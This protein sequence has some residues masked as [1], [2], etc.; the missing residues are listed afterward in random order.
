[1]LGVGVTAI[2]RPGALANA[3]TALSAGSASKP[4][5]SPLEP[6]TGLVAAR[7]EEAVVSAGERAEA[8]APALPASDAPVVAAAAG[9]A[10]AAEE[11]DT[12][13]EEEAAL[14]PPPAAADDAPAQT[15]AKLA[16]GDAKSAEVTLE[17]RIQS[18]RELM[19]A[20]KELR[21]FHQL[22]YLGRSNYGDAQA[23]RAW[24]EAAAQVKA[25]GEA[26]RTARRWAAI[27][28]STDALIHLAR[29]E[30]AVGRRGRAV[31]LLKK[32]VRSN[33]E[34]NDA[35]QLLAS[36]GWDPERLAKR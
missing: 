17:T 10:D 24:S 6:T 5:V 15:E 22:R 31:S 28:P 9:D 21:G 8:P 29:M 34:A 20:G 23:L 25:W 11:G 13:G 4:Q 33:P 30:R 3:R 19:A 14:E 36:F 18:A 32:I 2:G 12:D 26:A 1:V 7:I 35:K 16:A 27:D